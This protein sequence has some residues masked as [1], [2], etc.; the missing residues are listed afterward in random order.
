MKEPFAFHPSEMARATNL[1]A[2]P[3]AGLMALTAIGF[4]MTGQA[5]GIWAGTMSVAADASRRFWQPLIDDVAPTADGNE[6][7]AKEDAARAPAMGEAGFAGASVVEL[8]DRVRK[9]SNKVVKSGGEK[10]S[11]AP[12]IEAPAAVDDLKLISGIG[13]KIEQVLKGLGVTTYAQ[14]SA[15]SE[16]EIASIEQQLGLSGRI[17]RDDWSG[18][19]RLL[20][21]KSAATTSA[22]A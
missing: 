8:R 4:G 14:I 20:S 11:A 1:M 16:K 15:W 10:R 13:P 12:T 3:A 21:S 17:A 5:L 18:Q 19:A 9:A 22:E 6:I 2:H 7:Q